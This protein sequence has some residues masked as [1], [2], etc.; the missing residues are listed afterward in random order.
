MEKLRKEFL[1][2]L[3]E[4]KRLKIKDTKMAEL[5]EQQRIKYKIKK[6]D[7]KCWWGDDFDVRF[8]L[9]NKLKSFQKKIVLDIGGGIGIICSEMDKN[10]FRINMDIKFNVLVTCKKKT[11]SGICNICASMLNL[12]F[13]EGVFD[14]VICSNILEVGKNQDIINKKQ[15]EEYGVSVYPTVEKILREASN[16]LNSDGTI[17]ITTP[18]NAYFKSTK[19]TNKELQKALLNISK[20][21]KTYFYNTYKRLSKNK[22]LNLAN[23]IPQ[24]ASK[25][26]NPDVIIKN[27]AKEQSHND[28]SVSFFVEVKKE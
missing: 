5:T 17:F 20:K 25:F 11:D 21:S 3:L 18:N 4:T 13:R 8:Y 7:S 14:V 26:S 16:V 1:K 24:L 10:N 27:L 9:I 15:I 2:V 22:K 28:Y 6:I 23:V 12:P 19:L